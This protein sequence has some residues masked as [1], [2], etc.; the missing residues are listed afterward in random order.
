[1]KIFTWNDIQKY[2]NNDIQESFFSQNTGISIGSF[3]GLHTGHRKI[4]ETLISSCKKQNLLSGVI[5]FTRPLPSIKHKTDYLGDLSTL[6][7]RLKLFEQFGLDF[8]L[9]IDFDEEFASI[10]GSDFL[11]IIL[12]AFSMQ[13]LVE[14]IDFRCGFKGSTDFLAIKYWAEK[15]KIN[16][17]FENP[18]SYEDGELKEERISSSYIRN[19]IFKGFFSSVEKLLLRPYAIEIP[20]STK[21]EKKLITQALPKNGIY[22]AKT[23]F[24]EE[25]KMEISD[26]FV[27]LKPIFTKELEYPNITEI[28]VM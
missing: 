8:V 9:I 28:I 15:N 20:N 19:M 14:G 3:D 11:T 13:L 27:I 25:I 6:N 24:G 23:N 2:L 21:I 17:I 7:Q 10:L 12:N 5:S 1:M 16:V 4:I 26:D 18:V 22:N